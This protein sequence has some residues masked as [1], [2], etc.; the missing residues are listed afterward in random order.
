M[1][2][3][4]GAAREKCGETVGP[5]SAVRLKIRRITRTLGHDH[6]CRASDGA[7]VLRE[8]LRGA[9]D[10][11]GSSRRI[12]QKFGDRRN[13]CIS[14]LQ[15]DYPASLA[16]SI[17]KVLKIFHVRTDHDRLS[18]QDWFDRVLAAYATKA[19]PYHHD[20]RRG[21]PFPQFSGGVYDQDARIVL[22]IRTRSEV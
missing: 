20:A 6:R 9:S 14:G 3:R 18:G 15:L 2:V 16:K 11:A 12:S 5:Q 22:K 17:H 4:G 10:Q 1:A 13:K 8:R 19:F 7:L 21:V